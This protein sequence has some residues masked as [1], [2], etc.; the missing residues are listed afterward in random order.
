LRPLVAL[1]LLR[2][3]LSLFLF[4]LLSACGAPEGK[5]TDPGFQCLDE[6]SSAETSWSPAIN[7]GSSSGNV[8]VNRLSLSKVGPLTGLSDPAGAS[9]EV[10]FHFEVN[11]NLGNMGSISLVAEAERLPSN[12]KGG[13]YP[14]LVSLKD[15][16]GKEWLQFSRTGSE[17][18]CWAAG[19]YTCTNSSCTVNQK[20]SLGSSSVYKG[21]AHW[22][23]YQVPPFGFLSTNVFPNCNWEEDCPFK[24]I[25]DFESTQ[26]PKGKY[27]AKY[28][29]LT[30]N[31]SQFPDENISLKLDVFLK[32]N[33][34]SYQANGKNGKLD[35]NV[36]FVGD[37]NIQASQT[38]RGKRNLDALFQHVND[39]YSGENVGIQLRKLNVY[40]WKCSDGGDAYAQVAFNDLDKLFSE[41][42]G[43]IPSSKEGQ[44][45]NLFLISSIGSGNYLGVSG[46]ISGPPVN[47]TGASGVVVST[48]NLLD[49]FNPRCY[50]NDCPVERQDSQFVDMAV[51]V[52]HEIG[53][54]LGLNHPSEANGNRHDFLPDTPECS[55]LSGSVSHSSCLLGA[56]CYNLC[57]DYDPSGTFCSDEFACQ[58]NHVMWWTTKNFS[59]S[60]GS[61]DGNLFSP[62]SAQ[63]LLYSPFVR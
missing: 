61:G 44:A 20:C 31:Y 32:K 19:Y 56:S 1:P 55:S 7:G 35:L 45:V 24:D 37:K 14:M 52:S 34:K 53:H 48:F 46:A 15:G 54:Y 6:A 50:S 25:F 27:E 59:E 41:G 33:Q 39:H 21:R 17:G 49:E 22:E 28:V 4:S 11:E 60:T 30:S 36:I 2:G 42:S 12:F 13:V 51:T 57:S 62:H 9:Q 10:T 8:S 5:S 38:A 58:F 26:V 23:Q 16:N 63:I 3:S 47:H 40:E 43:L 29:L 18:D